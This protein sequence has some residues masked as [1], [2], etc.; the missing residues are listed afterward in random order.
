MK[1]FQKE[2]EEDVEMLSVYMF[3]FISYKLIDITEAGRSTAQFN[4]KQE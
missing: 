3:A 1:L 4:T 2:E